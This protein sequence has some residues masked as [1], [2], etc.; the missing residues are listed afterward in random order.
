MTD[1]EGDEESD[2][3]VNDQVQSAVVCLAAQS[4]SSSYKEQTPEVCSETMVMAR[5]YSRKLSWATSRIWFRSIQQRFSSQ[6]RHP[7]TK[8]TSAQTVELA[9][10]GAV[11]SDD[12]GNGYASL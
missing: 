11:G 2:D 5:W 12:T 3:T 4:F 8:N 9:E 10:I 6:R 7:T 1:R